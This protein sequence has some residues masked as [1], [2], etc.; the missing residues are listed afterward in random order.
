VEPTA[1][2]VVVVDGVGGLCQ[3]QSLSMEV[4]VGWIQWWSC[5]ALMAPIQ[6]SLAGRS[7]STVIV[8]GG[9]SGMEPT[10]PIIVIDHGD[11]SHCRQQWRSIAAVTMAVFV[12]DGR[13]CWRRQW[14]GANGTALIVVVDGSIKDA[15]A[16]AAINRRCRQQ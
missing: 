1:P 2:I 15:I 4:V 9:D 13:H 8:N 10:A 16:A 3:R 14:D 6:R 11:G 5:P 7:S 12:D